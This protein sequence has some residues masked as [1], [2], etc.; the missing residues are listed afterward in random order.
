MQLNM[1]EIEHQ[2]N[3]KQEQ[4]QEI[5]N[6]RD[7]VIILHNYMSSK[8]PLIGNLTT[9]NAA[10]DILNYYDFM[11]HYGKNMSP[12]KNTEYTS[13]ENEII[14]EF[15]LKYRPRPNQ[16]YRNAQLFAVF[17]S[18]CGVKYIEGYAAEYGPI[19]HAWNTINDKLIDV[20]FSMRPKEIDATYFGTEIPAEFIE[21]VWA[22]TNRYAM[23]LQYYLG[24][25]DLY[26]GKVS[27]TF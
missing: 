1:D 26:T 4:K 17:Y 19:D 15:I 12:I 3:L 18:H 6:L 10:K 16:P 21:Q 23:L 7:Y 20:T 11:L 8:I 5:H 27:A 13:E 22:K 25:V 9:Q 24:I 2:Y 14:K